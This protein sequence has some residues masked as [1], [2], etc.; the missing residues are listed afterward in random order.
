[1]LRR[2][3]KIGQSLAVTLPAEY[4]KSNNLKDKDFVE[5]NWDGGNVLTITPHLEEVKVEEKPK[6]KVEAKVEA[7][8]KPIPQVK[9]YVCELPTP[10]PFYVEGKPLCAKCLNDLRKLKL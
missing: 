1:V 4:V 3:F 7:E 2:L 5:V 10:N 9:C 6:V 8:T